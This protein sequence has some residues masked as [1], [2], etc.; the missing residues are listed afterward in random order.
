MNRGNG[1][2]REE[3]PLMDYINNCAVT[4]EHVPWSYAHP[5]PYQP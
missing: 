2:L 1:Y 3:F 5:Y 4:R